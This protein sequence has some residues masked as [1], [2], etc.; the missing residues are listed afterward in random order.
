[1]KKK[2]KTYLLVFAVSWFALATQTQAQTSTFSLEEAKQFAM[3]N[4]NVLHNTNLDITKAQKEVWKTITI[5]LPQVTGSANYN[6]FL[7]LPVSLIPGEFFGGEPGTYMPVQFGQDYSSDFGFTVSQQIFDG[8]YIVGVGSSQ[9]YLNLARQANEK[10][11]IDIR[12]A[13][14]QSYYYV[15]IG[16]ENKIV[17]QE[18]LEN[19]NKLYTETKAYF[20]NGFREEQDVDQMRLMVKN[21]ENEVVKAEREIKIAMVVLKYAMGFELEKEIE[22]SDEL[23]KFLNPLLTVNNISGFDFSNHIDYRLAQTNFSV[24]EKLLNL[25]KAAFL[26][27]LS[28]FY[29]Y[30]KTAFGNSANLFKSSISWYPSSLVG[31]QLSIP[32]F[33]SGQKMLKVQQA[34]IEVD[35]A[36]TQRKLAEITLQKDY[37]TAVAEMESALEKFDNDKENRALA[38]KILNKSK[39]KFNNGIT[40]STELSQIETQYIQSYGAYIG[41][42]LQLLQADLKLKK[43]NG[44]L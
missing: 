10:T 17:M 18:N 1:M 34:N 19:I 22:L 32:I 25:E 30:S 40:S 13:V 37:L 43:A 11:E 36:A 39:I 4:S 44:T 26:P 27:R 24:S 42:T 12:D 21:A 14:T 28:G 9:I 35:K 23:D 8:S 15:L 29:S 3:E 5:G 6:K 2:I 7:N 41:S 20:E 38:E 16:Q 33:N 31:F